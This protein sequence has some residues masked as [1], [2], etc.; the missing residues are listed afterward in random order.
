MG[1]WDGDGIDTPGLYRQSDGYVYLRNSNTQGIADVRF[2]FGNPG[3]V[4]LAGDF[5]GDGCDTVSLFRPSE[6]RV[7]V[8]NRLGSEDV[9]LGAADFT[10]VFGNPGDEPFVGDFNG[11]GFDEVGLHRDTTGRVYLRFS[12]T[13]GIAD[14]DF[15]YGNPQDRIVAGDWDGDGT[16]SPALFRPSN[17]THYFRFTNSTGTA[18][19]LY[20]WGVSNWVP[21][22]AD[23]S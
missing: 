7:Y 5:D 3:D 21:V 9:G 1:D 13:T 18:D 11:D 6:Q 8:I 17:T 14:L 4:P 19:A 23:H 12:L 16:D 20:I 22:A 10:F 15:V 2:F